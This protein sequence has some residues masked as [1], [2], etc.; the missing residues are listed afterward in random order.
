MARACRLQHETSESRRRMTVRRVCDAR[1]QRVP[2]LSRLPRLRHSARNT[3][4][5]HATDEETRLGEL[6]LGEKADRMR[7]HFQ[8]YQKVEGDEHA[9]CI[10]ALLAMKRD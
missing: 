10:T 4:L 7:R 2:Q 8:Q 5:K 9:R 1:H 3:D 6:Q